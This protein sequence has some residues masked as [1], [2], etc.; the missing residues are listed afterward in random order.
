MLL[1]MKEFVTPHFKPSVMSSNQKKAIR[2]IVVLYYQT[3]AEVIKLKDAGLALK[4]TKTIISIDSTFIPDVEWLDDAINCANYLWS[5]QNVD[6]MQ[7]FY[8]FSIGLLSRKE[9]DVDCCQK[10][11]KFLSIQFKLGSTLKLFKKL[12]IL[13]KDISQLLEQLHITKYVQLNH[14]FQFIVAFYP[15]TKKS[16]EELKSFTTSIKKLC[17]FS[18][19]FDILYAHTEV[20]MR[21][22]LSAEDKWIKI[23]LNDQLVL[24]ERIFEIANIT[25]NPKCN[26]GC[27][28]NLYYFN[29]FLYLYMNFAFITLKKSEIVTDDY[30][31]QISQT[32]MQVKNINYRTA[33]SKCEKMKTFWSNNLRRLSYKLAM[34]FYQK[35]QKY[36]YKLVQLFFHT[37]QQFEKFNTEDG[38]LEHLFLALVHLSMNKKEPKKCM[39]LAALYAYAY[40]K[41]NDNT[42]SFWIRAKIELKGDEEVQKMTYKDALELCTQY[43]EFKLPIERTNEVETK[44]L[45]IE[46]QSYSEKWSSKIPMMHTVKELCNV[47]DI[48]SLI[49]IILKVYGNCDKMIHMNMPAIFHEIMKKYKVHLS[50]QHELN[51]WHLAHFN[52]VY[53]S[54]CFKQQIMKNMEDMEQT[55][56]VQDVLDKQTKVITHPD[57]KCDLV[58]VYDSLKL[59]KYN[60]MIKH[61]NESLMLI[62]ASI[63][64]PV[65][66]PDAYKL[67]IGLGYEYLMHKLISKSVQAFNCGLIISEKSGNKKN[68]IQCTG[69]LLENADE[70]N[71]TIKKLMNR[72]DELCIEL[73]NGSDIET[74]KIIITYYLCKV[75][76]LIYHNHIVAYQVLEK[77]Q[78]MLSS[79]TNDQMK[80]LNVQLLMMQYR[81][82]TFPSDMIQ[83]ECEKNPLVLIH[84]A[85]NL[86]TDHS[87]VEQ[88]KFLKLY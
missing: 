20:V 16:N 62:T 59:D 68:I 65:D 77:A 69:Y 13:L 28:T 22:Y 76:C 8:L 33:G 70:F 63:H 52:F 26:C 79:I 64:N 25:K 42:T 71:D 50:E 58:S 82:N 39:Y 51:N 29:L 6:I 23:N 73:E 87:F 11:L 24:L 32:L 40:Q 55:K 66:Y 36:S 37:Y 67:L 43:P 31:V 27:K 88:G 41:Y 17:N 46:L 49:L 81:F 47:A 9:P 74:K 60:K 80:I 61:L 7:D 56:V 54:Y 4:L 5:M 57:D 21:Y 12:E 3:L 14:I 35:Y 45:E 83:E 84:S 72:A 38:D 30:L 53:Y 86:V 75:K 19:A 34:I 1:D 48:K 2:N 85:V 15:E 10:F 18:P 78:D 44:A